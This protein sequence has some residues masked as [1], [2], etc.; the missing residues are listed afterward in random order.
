MVAKVLYHSHRRSKL[1]EQQVKGESCKTMRVEEKQGEYRISTDSGSK[2]REF[3]GGPRV[4]TQHCTARAPASIC[5]QGTKILQ[6]SSMAKKKA[7]K[8]ASRT[9]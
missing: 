9:Q 8:T 2:L 6:A 5:G 4:R 3:P 1:T 7:N